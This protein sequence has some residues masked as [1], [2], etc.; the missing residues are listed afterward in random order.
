MSK[1]A[2]KI[3]ARLE[4]SKEIYRNK[5]SNSAKPGKCSIDC[6]SSPSARTT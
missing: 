1:T 4:P 5:N 3:S 2:T 6:A